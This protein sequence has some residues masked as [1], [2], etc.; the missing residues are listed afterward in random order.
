MKEVTVYEEIY[1]IV[2]QIPRGKVTTYGDVARMIGRPFAPRL[3][4]YAMSRAPFG[5]PSHRVVNKAGSMLTGYA[6]GGEGEQ[7]S[8]LE[9]EGVTFL[10]NGNIDMGA[11]RWTGE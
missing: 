8:M 10:E 11:H 7:R 2:S 6:F 1:D 9:E 3:V 4:G 5:L